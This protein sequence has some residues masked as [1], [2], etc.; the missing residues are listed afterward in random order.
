MLDYLTEIPH[1]RKDEA[2]KGQEHS[3]DADR[4]SCAQ[5]DQFSENAR[6]ERAERHHS[7]VDEAKAGGH[8]SLQVIRRDRLADADQIYPVDLHGEGVEKVGNDEQRDDK[9][10]RAGCQRNKRD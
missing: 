8:S 1:G 6:D 7:D 10:G 3:D 5:A 4:Q 9:G 2:E